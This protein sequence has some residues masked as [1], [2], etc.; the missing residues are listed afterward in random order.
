MESERQA[1]DLFW[2]RRVSAFFDGHPHERYP[3]DNE[4]DKPTV[5]EAY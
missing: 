3:K 5:G 1:Q 2:K 4:N